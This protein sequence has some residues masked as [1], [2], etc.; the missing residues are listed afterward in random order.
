MPAHD[1]TRVLHVVTTMSDDEAARIGDIFITVTGDK[2]VLIRE[3]FEHTEAI[4]KTAVCR[5]EHFLQG[6]PITGSNR[7]TDCQ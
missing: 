2:S 3:H 6:E 7:R 5:T 4:D 1:R